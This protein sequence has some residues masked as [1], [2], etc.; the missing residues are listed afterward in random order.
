MIN[1]VR[2]TD[3]LSLTSVTPVYSPACLLDVSS[4]DAR[5]TTDTN[6]A[7][8]CERGYFNYFDPDEIED[9]DGVVLACTAPHTPSQ[10][11]ENLFT[12]LLS[13][14]GES[15]FPGHTPFM[16]GYCVGWLS[17]IAVAQSDE[18]ATGMLALTSL[19][20][21]FYEQNYVRF[22]TPAQ[23]ELRA[24]LRGAAC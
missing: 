9:E 10:I 23:R 24:F 1:Q 16:I 14:I 5:L 3:A 8:G 13:L 21:T 7:D 15:D 6:F 11:L 22:E 17:A 2:V 20:K 4:L 12:S 19:V 18:A